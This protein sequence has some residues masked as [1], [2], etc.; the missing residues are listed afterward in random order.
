MK[1]ILFVVFVILT[2]NVE[3]NS[4]KYR[5]GELKSLMHHDGIC[6][7]IDRNNLKGHYELNIFDKTNF[8]KVYNHT[9]DFDKD[10]PLKSTCLK[11]S[12]KFKEKE[13]YTAVL[14]TEQ[15]NFGTDFCIID[16][17]I[18]SYDGVECIKNNLSLWTKIE[19]FIFKFFD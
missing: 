9:S 13:I 3:A 2:S 1:Y 6:F 5:G 19:L 15:T 12:Y 14:D 18:G 8:H 10:Y 7:Y 4:S 17:G 16:N 11:V